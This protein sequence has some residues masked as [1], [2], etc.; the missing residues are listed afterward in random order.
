MVFSIFTGLGSYHH[1]HFWNIFTTLKFFCH[2]IVPINNY[3]PF[4]SNTPAWGNHYSTFCLRRFAYFGHFIS[5]ESYNVWSFVTASF[6]DSFMLL[7]NIPLY[8]YITFCLSIHLIMDT[9]YFHLFTV[10][11][12]AAVNIG[13]RVS[14][15]G[16]P[17]L[18]SLGYISSSRIG[19]CGIAGVELL[20]SILIFKRN[21]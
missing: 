9:G 14:V 6:Q 16:V 5:M 12:N 19:R 18:N 8:E 20:D 10:M 21:C 17:V 4:L 13:I 11:D 15:V 2:P 3:S 1:N 7:N